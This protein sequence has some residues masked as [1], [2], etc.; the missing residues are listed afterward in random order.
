MNVLFDINHPAHVHFFKHALW[1]LENEG[2][3]CL[4]TSRKKDV[5]LELLDEYEIEHVPLTSQGSGLTSLGKEWAIR[6]TKMVNVARKFSP[7]IIASRP[8][9]VAVHTSKLCRCNNVLFSDS[10]PPSTGSLVQKVVRK[11]TYPF[12]DLVCTPQSLNRDYGDKHRR[13]NGVFE[14][15]YLHPNRFEPRAEVLS[16]HGIDPTS[17]FFILRFIAWEA[18]HDENQGGLSRSSKRQIVEFLSE[19]GKVYITSE[20]EL[21]SEF[22]Q[23]RLPLPPNVIHHALS[24]ADL[25]V[26]DSQTMATEAAVL[27]TPTVRSNSFAG[28]EDMTNFIELQERYGLMYSTPDEHEAIV[29]IEEIVSDERASEKWSDR[30]SELVANSSDITNAIVNSILHVGR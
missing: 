12:A 22:E 15:A 21:P 20:A 10:D 25:Y 8:N 17:R 30:R 29:K 3:E 13:L 5:T 2:H 6:G 19:R 1:E 4:V 27:G 23:Y 7:D 26:G 14:L 18:F 24:Y 9:P 28:T 16:E 11:T